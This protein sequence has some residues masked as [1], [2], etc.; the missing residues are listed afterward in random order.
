MSITSR[1]KKISSKVNIKSDGEPVLI[2]EKVGDL[3]YVNLYG[4]KFEL[5][6]NRIEEFKKEYGTKYVT[7]IVDDI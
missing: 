3:Y 6:E 4:K 2:F 1:L 5:P 7:C